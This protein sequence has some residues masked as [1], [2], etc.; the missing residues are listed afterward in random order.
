MSSLK[1]YILYKA[2][3]LCDKLYPK[4]FES[5]QPYFNRYYD[6]CG[7]PNCNLNETVRT[8]ACPATN[9]FSTPRTT[10]RTTPHT[11]EPSTDKK[12]S[13]PNIFEENIYL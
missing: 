1:C 11:A 8:G 10:P 5:C 9:H 4:R 12:S 2:Y 3:H 13:S 6:E 7:Y